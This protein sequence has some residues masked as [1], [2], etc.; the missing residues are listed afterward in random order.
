MF[1]GESDRH[2][3]ITARSGN[4]YEIVAADS[5]PGPEWM[6][7]IEQEMKNNGFEVLPRIPDY[8]K[9]VVGRRKISSPFRR[10]A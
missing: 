5:F 3:N 1:Q 7:D 4:Q 9:T 8:P 6:G 2:F 10:E